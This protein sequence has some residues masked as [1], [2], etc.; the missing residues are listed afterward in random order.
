MRR[1][2]RVVAPPEYKCGLN[3]LFSAYSAGPI[4]I[5][6]AGIHALQLIPLVDEYMAGAI[7][8]FRSGPDGVEGNEDDFIFRNAQQL[9][10]VPE[11]GQLPQEMMAGLQQVA[12]TQSATF[13]VEVDVE[14]GEMKRKYYAVI[15]RASGRELV[16]L[17]FYW[18]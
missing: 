18:K 9:A 4:N 13:E 1:A 7:I 3:D 16:T 17:T 2:K 11:M 14:M 5:N 6:T 15:R 8:A 12:G 10:M